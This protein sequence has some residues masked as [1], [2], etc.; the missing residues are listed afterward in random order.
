M[1]K[2]KWLDEPDHI[3]ESDMSDEE[4]EKEPPYSKFDK[5]E[6]VHRPPTQGYQSQARGSTSLG[7]KSFKRRTGPHQRVDILH[8]AIPTQEEVVRLTSCEGFIG[9]KI[10]AAVKA[11]RRLLCRMHMHSDGR[12]GAKEK[13]ERKTCPWGAE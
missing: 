11:P 6:Q 13:E 7:Q 9:P 4:E 3:T 5:V 8:I 1:S 10:K 2:T 12:D